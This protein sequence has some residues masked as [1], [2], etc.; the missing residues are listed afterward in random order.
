[1]AGTPGAVGTTPDVHFSKIL[2]KDHLFFE[3]H[4][5]NKYKKNLAVIAVE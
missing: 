1:V 4:D 2:F 3:N 5:K